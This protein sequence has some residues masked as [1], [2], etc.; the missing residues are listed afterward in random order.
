MDVPHIRPHIR[1]PHIPHIHAYPQTNK[2]NFLISGR[3]D[4]TAGS[5]SPFEEVEPKFCLT[6][7]LFFLADLRFVDI[8]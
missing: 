2:N 3:P 5:L 8:F 7:T 1:V 6:T 4:F